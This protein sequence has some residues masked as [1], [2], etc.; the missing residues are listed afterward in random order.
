MKRL[1][2]AAALLAFLLGASL[3]NAWYAQRLTED[4]GQRLRQAQALTQEEN[5]DQAQSVTRQVYED[6]QS[7]HFYFHTLMRH[8]DTDQILRGFRQVLEYL[9]LQEPY[10]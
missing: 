8:S 5:W 9:S 6:W 10:H 7:H 2:I 1:W 3:A 4:L